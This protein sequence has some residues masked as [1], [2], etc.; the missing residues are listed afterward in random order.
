MAGD[1]R[2]DARTRLYCDSPDLYGAAS[3][4]RAQLKPLAVRRS[5]PVKHRL[6]GWWPVVG[7]LLAV[8]AMVVGGAWVDGRG[9]FVAGGA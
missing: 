8:L 2:A 7:V 6:I 9:L 1:D 3:R 5:K 4:Y